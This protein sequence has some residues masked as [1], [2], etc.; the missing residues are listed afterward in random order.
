MTLKETRMLEVGDRL[1]VV[2]PM[3]NDIY[4]FGDHCIVISI[5]ADPEGYP[6]WTGVVFNKELR[7]EHSV[8]FRDFRFERAPSKNHE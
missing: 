2:N 5:D 8:D 7:L 1:V 6:S 4:E 3:P